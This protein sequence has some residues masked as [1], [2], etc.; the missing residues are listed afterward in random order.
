MKYG[1]EILLG[2]PSKSVKTLAR[3]IGQELASMPVFLL[4]N[5]AY[6]LELRN[7]I[8]DVYHQ[9]CGEVVKAYKEFKRKEKK[10]ENDRLV[11]GTLSEQKQTEWDNA[12]KLF[13]K[14]LNVASV[15]SESLGEDVPVLEVINCLQSSLIKL[16]S[17]RLGRQRRGREQYERKRHFSLG[18]R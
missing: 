4:A 12:K 9:V 16:I 14:L 2:L 6:S 18:W 1:S 8:F 13:E 5:P 15:M 10:M 3:V 11:F 17:L 7:E